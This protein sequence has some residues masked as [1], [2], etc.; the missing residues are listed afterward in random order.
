M[1]EVLFLTDPCKEKAF[2]WS[3]FEGQKRY[4]FKVFASDEIMLT[5]AFSGSY[6]FVNPLGR[7]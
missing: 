2:F 7:I 5:L 1:P 3:V 6:K 4:S